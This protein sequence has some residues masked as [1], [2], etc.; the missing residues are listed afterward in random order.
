MA[1]G[2]IHNTVNLTY[3]LF[4]TVHILEREVVEKICIRICVGKER[5]CKMK[6]L[7][8]KVSSPTNI[9]SWRNHITITAT[10]MPSLQ[11]VYLDNTSGGRAT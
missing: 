11:L 5:A 4:T 2:T 10:T 9:V 6:G 1:N 3:L 8:N 7:H